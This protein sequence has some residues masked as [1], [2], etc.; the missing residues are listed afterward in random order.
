LEFTLKF[1]IPCGCSSLHG[2]RDVADHFDELHLAAGSA[3]GRSD[4]SLYWR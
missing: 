3:Q 2:Q 4:E 1:G